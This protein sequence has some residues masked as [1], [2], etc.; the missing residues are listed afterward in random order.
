MQSHCWHSPVSSPFC[1]SSSAGIRLNLTPLIYYHSTEQN[2]PLWLPRARISVSTHTRHSRLAFIEH[3]AFMAPSSR[4]IGPREIR[5][6]FESGYWIP[7]E[8]QLAV[9]TTM[10][11]SYRSYMPGQ[12]AAASR[13]ASASVRAD[14]CRPIA[15]TRMFSPR[16]AFD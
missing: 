4:R 1:A 2:Q 5:G 14:W 11:F 3:V 8:C 6:R 10:Y 16:P 7:S 15:G 13:A 9:L 12:G